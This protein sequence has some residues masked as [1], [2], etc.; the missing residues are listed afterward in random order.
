MR[1]RNQQRTVGIDLGD[2]KH[3]VCVLD[4]KGEILREETITDTRESL[5][6]LGKRQP[7]A[8]MVT[9]VGM[10]SPWISRFL[11]EL[12]HRV[13]VANPRKVAA[14]YKNIRKCDRNDAELL[15]LG[16]EIC[17]ALRAPFVL[18]E[19]A[20]WA[21]APLSAASWKRRIRAGSTWLFCGW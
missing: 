9:E 16:E 12:G 19:A 2:R 11:M 3:S 15:A 4:H 14:I 5:K 8:L 6:A 18:A 13:L 1:P 10:H 20:G 7:G 17:T 21:A